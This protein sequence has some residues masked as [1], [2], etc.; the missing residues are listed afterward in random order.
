MKMSEKAKRRFAEIR[1]DRE[2]FTGKSFVKGLRLLCFLHTGQYTVN[3]LAYKLEVSEQTVYRYLRV[4]EDM[5][6]CIDE[7]LDNGYGKY[8]IA[9]DN[10][11]MCGN[12]TTNEVNEKAA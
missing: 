1:K 9:Q 2:E 7:T 12:T 10:C 8:F 5:G 6:I 11:P 3:D 4:I